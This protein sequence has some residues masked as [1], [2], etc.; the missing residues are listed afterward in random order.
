MQGEYKDK[1]NGFG[2]VQS[3]QWEKRDLILITELRESERVIQLCKENN[4]NNN[5]H[6]IMVRNLQEV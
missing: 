2:S 1:D 3:V 4:N 6:I 5:F